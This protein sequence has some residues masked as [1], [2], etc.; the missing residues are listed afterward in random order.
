MNICARLYDIAEA[1]NLI[2]TLP[3]NTLY[4]S[5][6]SSTNCQIIINKDRAYFLTD[7]RY[8]SEA[9][10]RLGA[11]FEVVCKD[12]SDAKDLLNDG[13]VGFE[14]DISYRQ[15][16]QLKQL[17]GDRKTVDVS[18]RISSLRDIKTQ[19]EIDCIVKA[20]KVTEIA[21]DEA[22]KFIKKGISEIELSAYIEYIMHKNG[23]ETAFDS[24]VAFG[25]HTANPHAHKSRST[26]ADGD[27]V[28]MDI[29][30][31][32]NGYCSDM[33][34]TVGYGQIGTKQ[35]EIYNEV[36][37]AQNLALKSLRAG[38]SGKD[39]DKIARDYFAQRGLDKYFIHSLGHGVGIDIHEGTGLTPREQAVLKENMVVTV[40][41]GLYID[42][43]FGVRIEDMA[44]IKESSVIDLTNA[45]KQLII[46]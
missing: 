12:L 16:R 11:H 23:C 3:S 36:F 24:I 9:R 26:V 40:E 42:G 25:K 28:T 39:G 32:Y 30:A 33:T 35:A 1:D 7:M 17:V 2:I 21:F 4:L 8:Y 45:D 46:L 34:R 27:F 18:D 20:Q 5:G 31:K 22:L 41:P 10:D 37:N 19:E 44:L 6:Y 13:T 43:E 14:A 38:M 29:G 15:Y